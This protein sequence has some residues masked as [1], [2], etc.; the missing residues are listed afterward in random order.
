MVTAGAVDER[1]SDGVG[2][3]VRV[4]AHLLSRAR[5]TCAEAQSITIAGRPGSRRA[6]TSRSS[7]VRLAK[8]TGTVIGSDGKPVEGVEV[9]SRAANRD[10]GGLLGQARRAR[11]KNGNFTLN[12]VPPGDY[13]L[14]TRVVQIMTS[15]QGDNVMVFRA[16]VHGDGGGRVGIRIDSAHRRR[17][18]RVG[19]RR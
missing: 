16:H 9:S 4:C 12:N 13:T 1:R 14:Q 2:A 11:D 8:I 18:R 5:R 10:F 19:H 6:P 17:R 7:P 3:Q 15:S